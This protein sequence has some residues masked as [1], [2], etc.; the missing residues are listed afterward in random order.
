MPGLPPAEIR[1]KML[2]VDENYEPDCPWKSNSDS[3]GDD[4]SLWGGVIWLFELGWVVNH[5][6]RMGG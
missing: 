4:E 2:A 3:A 1:D 6:V 5:G